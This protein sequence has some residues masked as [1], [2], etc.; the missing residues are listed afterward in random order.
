MTHPYYMSIKDIGDLN[1]KQID[2]ILDE[3]NRQIKKKFE[4]LKKSAKDYKQLFAMFD[5][6]RLEE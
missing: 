5:I 1:F 3:R 2:L 4:R 6:T